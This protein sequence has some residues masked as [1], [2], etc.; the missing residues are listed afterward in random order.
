VTSEVIAARTFQSLYVWLD[1]AFLVAFIVLLVWSR[2]YQALV[3]GVAGGIIYFVVDYGIF[4]RLLGTRSVA[5]ASPFW[6]LLWLSISYGVTNFAWI[7]LWLDRDGRALEWSLFIMG[8]WLFVAL[9]SQ[10]LGYDA[11]PISISRGTGQYHGVMALIMFLGYGG[12]CA[13]NLRPAAGW[14]RR[15]KPGAPAAERSATPGRAPLLGILAIGILVQFSWETILAISGIRTFHWNTL[16]VNSLLETNMGLPYLYLIHRAVARRW[17]EGLR[18]VG[19][20]SLALAPGPATSS[21]DPA[22]SGQD[23]A[24]AASASA[25]NTPARSP[26]PGE[27]M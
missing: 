21:Q 19:G 7:W 16:I 10:Q 24:V 13:Y 11:T 27:T 18:R 4:F 5:G 15:S 23:P 2:R 3:V 25:P 17:D 26:S 9:L 22:T 8:G 12:L 6:L 1:L 14:R 20:G